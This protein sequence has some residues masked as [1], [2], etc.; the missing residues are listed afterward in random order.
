MLPKK[1]KPRIGKNQ[2]GQA[3]IEYAV[4]LILFAGLLFVLCEMATV[5]YQWLSVQYAVNSGARA[6]RLA[7]DDNR[8]TAIR[9]E[10]NRV[11]QILLLRPLSDSEVTITPEGRNLTVDAEVDVQLHGLSGV[12]LMWFPDYHGIWTIH[13]KEIVRNEPIYIETFFFQR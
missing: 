7:I 4:V 8:I 12:F 5:C 6:G 2:K 10:I 11:S 1:A 9:E 3:V 13:V